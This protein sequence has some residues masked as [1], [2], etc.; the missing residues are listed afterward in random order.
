MSPAEALALGAFLPYRLSVLASRMS[1]ELSLL[2]AERYGIAIPEW[3]VIAVLGQHEDVS[4]DFVCVKTDM[5]KVT[6][7]RAVA[8]LLEKK[9][10]LR[11][12]SSTDRRRS[13]L[14]LSS[15]GRRVYAD[16]VPLA[17]SY[18]RRLLNALDHEARAALE[19]ALGALETQLG[20]GASDP[21]AP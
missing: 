21:A 8:R 7:S 12:A 18:E 15:A 10:L 3:R 17:R 9:L 5:D 16:I 13:M 4:A 20:I 6:V 1:R 11:R 2:Y 14:R 19:R